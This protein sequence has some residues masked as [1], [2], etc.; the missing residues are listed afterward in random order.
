MSFYAHSVENAPTDQWQLL[1]IHL[2]N[3]GKMASEFAE[4]FGASRWAALAGHCHDLGKATK[5]WQAWLRHVN[6][7]SDEFFRYYQG[8]PRHAFQGA[9]WLFAHSKQAG[10]LLSYCVAGHHAGLPDWHSHGEAGLRKRLEMS[11]PEPEP[12]FLPEPVFPERPPFILESHRIGFQLQ[13]FT[14]MLFSCLVDADFLDTE[15]ALNPEISSLRKA[16]PDIGTLYDIFHKNFS[17]L[18]KQ[19]DPSLQVNK[20]REQ[21]LQDCLEAA[22]LKPGLFSLTVPT[23]GGKTLSSMAFALEHARRHKL[24]RIIYVIPFTSIIEQNAGVF[25]RMLGDDA[26][27]EHHCNFIPDDTDWKTKLAAENWDAPVIVTTNVQFFDSFYAC[28]PSR[29]RKLHNIADSIVIFDEVQAIHVEKLEPC[30]E[31]IREL[32]KTYG[33]SCVLCTATQPAIEA[34]DSFSHGLHD[35]REII[36]DVPSLFKGLKRTEE[37]FIGE[38]CIDDITDRLMEHE[39]VLCIVNTRQQALDLFSSLPASEHNYHLSALMYPE[40]RSRKLDEIRTRLAQGKKCRVISTQLIEA[41]VDVDFP[42][43][44]RQSAGIDSIA[45]AAGRCN[46]NGKNAVPGKVYIFDIEGQQPV[47]F[48]RLAVQSACKL[49]EKYS[50]N[51]TVPECVRQYFQDYFWKNQSRLDVDGILDL[52]RPS[53][54]LEIQF[55]EISRFRMIH[56][57]TV[58]IIVAL[59]D[60]CIELVEQLRFVEHAGGILRKLQRYTVQVYPYQLDEMEGWLETPIPEIRVLRSAEI[61]SDHTGLR[62]SSPEGEAFFV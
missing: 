42:C 56:T 2:S 8:H 7:I 31:V 25:R 4:V 51:L 61:Y 44:F 24:R 32:S 52:C 49:F 60:K 10:K 47:S 53:Q 46:R 39:Q 18:R 57:A 12:D 36:K 16:L 3:V 28:K 14:R 13:F 58:P 20:K 45:Q 48:M 35:V 26:V 15:Q 6:D 41:G 54:N 19:A 22:G 33:V 17:V 21:V 55:R 23:G 5:E 62:C 11:L 34:S 29:C 59:E 30:L 37:V 43:V 50:G 40:H 9:K 1:D 27:I 38:L